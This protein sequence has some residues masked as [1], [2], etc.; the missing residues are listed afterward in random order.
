MRK[1]A[2]SG[3]AMNI[4]IGL[5]AALIALILLW[6]FHEKVFAFFSDVLLAGIKN[7]ILCTLFGWL[8]GIGSLMG[9]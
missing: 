8:P 6:V 4:I 2:L 7:F 9:C 5:I 1:A 3:A